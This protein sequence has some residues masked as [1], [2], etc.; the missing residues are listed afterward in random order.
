MKKPHPLKAIDGVQIR[1]QYFNVPMVI[2]LQIYLVVLETVLFVPLFHGGFSVQRMVDEIGGATVGVALLLLP[3]AILS[4]INRYCFGKVVCVLTDGGIHYSKGY[5][6][7]EEMRKLEYD[8]PSPSKHRSI[9]SS[10]I[11]LQKRKKAYIPEVPHYALKQI[12]RFR[13]TLPVKVSRA[14]WICT[15]GLAIAGIVIAACV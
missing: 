7:W 11:I 15:A 4:V 2:L 14:P 5:V 13:Q 8:Y 3:L 9:P 6:A 10:L 1:R 12:R